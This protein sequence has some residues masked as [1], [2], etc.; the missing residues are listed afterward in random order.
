MSWKAEVTDGSGFATNAL[1]FSSKT[2][3][4][5]YARDLAS[6]WLAVQ[7]WRVVECN[8]PVYE[9]QYENAFNEAGIE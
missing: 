2:R 1:R 8:D 4:E 9:G 5:A 6:R 3:A 7:D